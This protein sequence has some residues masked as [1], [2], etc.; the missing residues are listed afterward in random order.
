MIIDRSRIKKMALYAGLILFL[1]LGSYY[2]FHGSSQTDESRAKNRSTAARPSPTTNSADSDFCAR[3]RMEREQVRS[4]EVS[5]LNG[6]VNEGTAD[7]QARSNAMQRLVEI[8][9]DI[10]EE[11]KAENL[12][13]C[14]GARDCV[15]MV[16]PDNATLIIASS[17]MK[18][19]E[20]ADLTSELS[21]MME[22]EEEQISL[23][24][25]QH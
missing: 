17:P 7:S 11:M 6:V 19:D 24:F 20:V 4:R 9:Y 15:A 13:R 21:K 5:I 2:V 1:V 12:V 18:E 25:R 10:E 22:C 8:S 14:H 16:E 23:I 3:Y